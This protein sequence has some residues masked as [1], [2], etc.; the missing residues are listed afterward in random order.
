MKGRFP[1]F[2]LVRLRADVPRGHGRWPL[3]GQQMKVIR[4]ETADYPNEPA[5]YPCQWHCR[6]ETGERFS[7]GSVGTVA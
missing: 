4:N 7:R 6:D 3:L 1:N 5:R 2:A